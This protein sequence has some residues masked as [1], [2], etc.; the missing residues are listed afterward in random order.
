MLEGRS[1]RNLGRLD[2][3]SFAL[4]RAVE[5]DPLQGHAQN[6]L[7]LVLLAL[8]QPD[9]ALIALRAAVEAT[10]EL[11]Y[12]HNNLGLALE[13]TGDRSGAVAAYASALDLAPRHGAAAANLLRLG[14]ERDTVQVAEASAIKSPAEDASVTARSRP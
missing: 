14:P 1:L 7:G 12:V 3:A 10:P 6:L 11:G 5:L 13:R 2:E 8:D 9:Q 4:Q